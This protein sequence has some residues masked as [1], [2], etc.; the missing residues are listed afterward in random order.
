VSNDIFDLAPM[1]EYSVYI[2]KF[3]NASSVQDGTQTND[4]VLDRYIQ[5]DD[6][7]MEDKWV[8]STSDMFIESGTCEPVLPWLRPSTG[9][10]SFANIDSDQEKV[11][12]ASDKKKLDFF[13]SK[14]GAVSELINIIIGYGYNT[15]RRREIG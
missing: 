11:F 12:T 1:T 14:A 7:W 9:T 10:P 2:Q 6:W 3:G 5:T 4:D 15:R 8:Q 13:L